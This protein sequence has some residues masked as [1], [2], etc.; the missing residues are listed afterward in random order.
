MDNEISNNKKHNLYN[1]IDIDKD[2]IILEIDLEKFEE[3][4]QKQLRLFG[5]P[6]YNKKSAV[7]TLEPIP[8]KYIKEINI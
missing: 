4:H 7:F 2:I 6:A 1:K 3:D 5:D 8:T